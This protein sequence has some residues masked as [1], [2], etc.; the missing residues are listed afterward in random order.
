[1]VKLFFELELMLQIWLI[2]LYDVIKLFLNNFNPFLDK[3]KS[4]WGNS[5]GIYEMHFV[6]L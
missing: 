2:S 5:L 6:A 3:L 4:F 1:M